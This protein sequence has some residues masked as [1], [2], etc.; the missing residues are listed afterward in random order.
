MTCNPHS[1]GHQLYQVPMLERMKGC[2]RDWK[3]RIRL[4]GI[5]LTESSSIG[6]RCE[7][8]CLTNS[9]PTPFF[10]QNF[11]W[12]TDR[13]RTIAERNSVDNGEGILPFQ[14]IQRSALQ[15]ISR[16]YLT[17]SEGFKNKYH[18]SFQWW[19]I[20]RWTRRHA[21]WY[22]GA[23]S[24]SRTCKQHGRGRMWRT[25]SCHRLFGCCGHLEKRN[26]W[27]HWETWSTRP[28]AETPFYFCKTRLWNN[29]TDYS[30]A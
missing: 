17:R 24:S 18:H 21:L 12:P 3:S 19:K 6:P 25:F 13:Q 28:S 2:W 27:R 30:R 7:R 23:Y 10:F 9:I 8:K 11:R 5:A 14:G 1:F 20:P 22:R 26:C 15:F 29:V 4:K 16:K